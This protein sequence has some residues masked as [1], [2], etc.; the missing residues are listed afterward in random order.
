MVGEVVDH[1]HVVDRSA[2]LLPSLHPGERHEPCSNVVRLQPKRARGRVHAERILHVV[3]PRH[4]EE[5]LA[6]ASTRLL[7][8]EARPLGSE[9]EML[10]AVVGAALRGVRR[11][12]GARRMPSDRHGVRIGRRH[13]EEAILG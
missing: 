9:A 2:D 3:V 5:E 12:V 8:H 11:D 13:R 7:D 6:G 10:G 1:E 4:R